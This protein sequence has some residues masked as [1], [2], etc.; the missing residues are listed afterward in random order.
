MEYVLDS[1]GKPKAVLL[2]IDEWADIV[3]DL[4]ELDDIRAYDSA[5]SASRDAVPFEEAVREIDKIL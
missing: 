3:E 1:E 4:E 2:A 5:K